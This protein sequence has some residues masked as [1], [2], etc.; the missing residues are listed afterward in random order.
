LTPSQTRRVHAPSLSQLLY[1]IA[2]ATITDTDTDTVIAVQ[3]FLLVSTLTFALF[4]VVACSVCRDRERFPS[5][6]SYVCRAETSDRVTTGTVTTPS[7]LRAS[8]KETLRGRCKL[9]HIIYLSFVHPT[10]MHRR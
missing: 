4:I 8:L 1:R 7:F 9:I 3:R 2:T 5:H 6:Y 10:E